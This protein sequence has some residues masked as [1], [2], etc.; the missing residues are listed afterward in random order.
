[1]LTS[2]SHC[3]LLLSLTPRGRPGL[4]PAMAAG[5]QA[6][7]R[8]TG[9]AMKPLATLRRD[10]RPPP[11]MAERSPL[12]NVSKQAL[13]DAVAL[14]AGV[15]KKTAGIVLAATLDVIVASVCEGHKVSLVG[16]GSFDSKLRPERVVRNPKTG[17]NMV[18]PEVQPWARVDS[19]PC[20]FAAAAT[21]AAATSA[22]LTPRHAALL[23]SLL[24]AVAASLPSIVLDSVWMFAYR[25]PCPPSRLGRAS[26]MP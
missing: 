10:S 21:A 17:E 19:D 14:K 15:S 1:M 25:R 20:Y 22:A 23:L 11:L 13:V 12:P 8:D 4:L 9:G 16:F 26:R 6:W 7:R 3:A 24:A 18:V 5:G 2:G